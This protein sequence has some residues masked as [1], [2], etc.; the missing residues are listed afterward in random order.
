MGLF[1]GGA[2]SLLA[3]CGLLGGNSYRFKMTVEVDTPQGLRTGSSVYE[4]TAFKTSELITG[5]SSSD[6][7]LKGEALAVDLPGG[8]TLFALLKTV[9]PMR[10]DL[11]LMSMAALDPAFRNDRTESTKRIASGNGVRSPSEVNRSDYPLLVTFRDLDDPETVERVADPSN[12]AATFGPGYALRQITV[13]VTNEP[14]TSGILR[15]LPWLPNV[16]D[17][18]RGKDFRPKGIPLGNF[19]GLFSTELS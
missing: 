3:G 11:A 13:Q 2:A 19:K 16:Y 12:L 5:G 7:I 10:E 18:L 1:A 14:V 8:Q 17:M 4:V 15:K 9:N 6:S